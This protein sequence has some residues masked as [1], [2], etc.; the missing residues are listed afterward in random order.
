M[1]EAVLGGAIDPKRLS[2]L[3]AGVA[4]TRLPAAEQP[5]EAQLWRAN[6]HKRLEVVVENLNAILAA[7]KRERDRLDQ[8]IAALEGTGTR[9]RK[10]GRRGPR[11][12]SAEGRRRISEAMKKRWA[13]KK[14]AKSAAA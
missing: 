3:P 4:L 6:G 9:G 5:V 7:F 10:L 1:L 8:A 11:K 2:Q 14:K 12:I 13:A